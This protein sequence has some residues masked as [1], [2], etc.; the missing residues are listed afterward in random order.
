MRCH[1]VER[2]DAAAALR[3]PAVEHS[4]VIMLPRCKQSVMGI[5]RNGKIKVEG[6]LEWPEGSRVRVELSPEDWIEEW[7]KLVKEISEAS[8]GQPSAVQ[9][10]SEMR[11]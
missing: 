4:L 9:L 8:R 3:I 10:L 5:V 1:V 2:Q 11:R 6:Q 7:D